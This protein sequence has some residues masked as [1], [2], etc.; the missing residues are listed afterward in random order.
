MTIHFH[1]DI[2]VRPESFNLTTSS[3][4]L[5]ELPPHTSGPHRAQN[6]CD[7]R[8]LSWVLQCAK[9][10]QI[11]I[12]SWENAVPV[13]SEE[14]DRALKSPPETIRDT[15]AAKLSPTSWDSRFN[16]KFSKASK[17]TPTYKQESYSL[18]W[19]KSKSFNV[20]FI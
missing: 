20:C 15:R 9:I 3:T 4:K 16:K 2:G 19:E 6:K 8:L 18:M 5:Y 13:L 14:N 11:E 1:Q 7:I 17:S 12:C 10:N